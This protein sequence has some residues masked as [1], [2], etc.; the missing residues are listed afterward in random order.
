MLDI[1]RKE[2][3][4]CDF[5]QGMCLFQIR[6]LDLVFLKC[7]ISFAKMMWVFVVYRVSSVSLFGRRYWI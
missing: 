1:V 7:R 2:A 5:L 6:I 4:N 3:E